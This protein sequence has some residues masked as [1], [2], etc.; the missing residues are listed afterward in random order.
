MHGVTIRDSDN[1]KPNV[2]LIDI[3]KTV[4]D[5]VLQSSWKISFVE[6]I[7]ETSKVL[8]QI[9]DEQRI[10]SGKELFNISEGI[11]QIIEGNFEACNHDNE[12]WLSLRVIDG[13]E[14]DIET[15]DTEILE[16]IRK[17]FSSVEDLIY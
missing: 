14:F 7:G 9:S 3:L 11:Q 15:K 6:C 5:K 17:S 2:S 8:H 13:W 12:N 4:G 10:I 1:D 16:N